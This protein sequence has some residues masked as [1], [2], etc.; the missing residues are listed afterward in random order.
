[1]LLVTLPQLFQLLTQYPLLLVDLQ[2]KLLLQLQE[3]G[4]LMVKQLSLLM[5]WSV[6]YQVFLQPKLY[7]KLE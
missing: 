7:A 6:L 1:M 3:Q 4:S 5:V 2:K